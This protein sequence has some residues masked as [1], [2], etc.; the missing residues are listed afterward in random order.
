MNNQNKF[1][2]SV[3][4]WIENSNNP[5]WNKKHSIINFPPSTVKEGIQIFFTKIEI[6]LKVYVLHPELGYRKITANIEDYIGINTFIA[7]TNSESS[8]KLYINAK[9]AGETQNKDLITNLEISDYVMVKVFN[10]DINNVQ[11]DDSIYAIF[12]ARIKSLDHND[13]TAK[14]EFFTIGSKIQIVRLPIDRIKY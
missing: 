7:L 2:F 11:I 1:D 14:F 4:F 8:T 5:G 3:T 13:N 9:Q 6:L 10:N 12:P